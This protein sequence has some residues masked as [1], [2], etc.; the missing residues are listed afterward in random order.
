MTTRYERTG[1]DSDPIDRRP[2]TPKPL[3]FWTTRTPTFAPSTRT[4]PCWMPAQ[5][6]SLRRV[7][8]NPRPRLGFRSTRQQ[9]SMSLEIDSLHSSRWSSTVFGARSRDRR[10][11]RSGRRS[12]IRR[13][14][15]S[16]SRPGSSTVTPE[17]LSRPPASGPPPGILSAA[18]PA[19]FVQTICPSTW[20]GQ[21]PCWRSLRPP[22]DRSVNRAP[23]VPGLLAH[24]SRR[25]VVLQ[26]RVGFDD[27]RRSMPRLTGRA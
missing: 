27:H 14:S 19:T 24:G 17:A 25:P 16:S 23:A 20:E 4:L 12:T 11:A 18:A 7:R 22:P 8:L 2:K 15:V 1:F 13:G 26:L 21:I 3:S 10:S 9:C 6:W 5:P